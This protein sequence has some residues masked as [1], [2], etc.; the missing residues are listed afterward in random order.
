MAKRRS[1]KENG[2]K[3]ETQFYIKNPSYQRFDLQ[4]MINRFVNQSY[5]SIFSKGDENEV[6]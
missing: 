2:V 3:R 6:V 1:L 5:Q 4:E